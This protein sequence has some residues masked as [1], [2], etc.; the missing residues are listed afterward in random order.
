[1][2]AGA[3]GRNRALSF[4]GSLR[5]VGRGT[6]QLGG[7]LAGGAAFDPVATGVAGEVLE[8][9]DDDGAVTG[10]CPGAAGGQEGDRRENGGLHNVRGAVAINSLNSAVSRSFSNSGSSISFSRSLNP[11]S[12]AIRM[13]WIARSV[14]PAFA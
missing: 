12:S 14:L 8:S 1:E 4:G 2:D 7:D 13:Y 3:P 10:R 9:Q 11:S 5:R 6:V